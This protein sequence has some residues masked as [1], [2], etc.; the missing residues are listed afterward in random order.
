MIADQINLVYY[1]TKN[2][3]LDKWM[4][5]INVKPFLEPVSPL[6][7]R[8]REFHLDH[9]VWRWELHCMEQLQIL[10]HWWHSPIIGRKMSTICCYKGNFLFPNFQ[11][12]ITISDT[13][14]AQLPSRNRQ[15]FFWMFEHT[16]GTAVQKAEC[17]WFGDSG[18]TIDSGGLETN[19]KF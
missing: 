4:Q 18:S 13:G 1:S 10:R 11:E 5:E 12:H 17:A 19:L 2:H 14:N 8:F 3:L 7:E 9:G 16:S 15:L 6:T